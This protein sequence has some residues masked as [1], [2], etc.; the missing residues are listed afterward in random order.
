MRKDELKT[1]RLKFDDMR[2]AA[3]AGPPDDGSDGGALVEVLAK[4][5]ARSANTANTADTT[6]RHSIKSGV[7]SLWPAAA[8]PP[9]P[10][11]HRPGA[12]PRPAV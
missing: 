12:D 2:G 9:R 6:L 8:L 5:L 4:V 1:V 11:R 7:Y 10:T 3:D